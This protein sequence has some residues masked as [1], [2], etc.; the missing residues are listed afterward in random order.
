MVHSTL[1]HRQHIFWYA[2]WMHPRPQIAPMNN[3]TINIQAVAN[4]IS[5]L[6]PCI[7]LFS[8]SLSKVCTLSH[9]NLHQ[10]S[11]TKTKPAGFSSNMNSV[12]CS[13]VPEL[14]NGCLGVGWKW[15]L[16]KQWPY[17]FLLG[18]WKRGPSVAFLCPQNQRQSNKTTLDRCDF[19]LHPP[20]VCLEEGIP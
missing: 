5:P 7:L 13:P 20:K 19:T 17:E 18:N 2:N 1:C 4:P 10:K 11:G 8:L 15:I 9:L 16:S 6:S 14:S 12:N 3:K